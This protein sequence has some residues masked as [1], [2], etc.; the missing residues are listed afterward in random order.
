MSAKSIKGSR[1]I[2]FKIRDNFS[3]VKS[4]DTY[5][6]GQWVLS[7]FDAKRNL[8]YYELD[9]KHFKK[10]E[11]KFELIVTDYSNNIANFTRLIYW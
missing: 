8:L 2:N 4:Y 10:G 7:K 6:N 5:I 9:N 1:K 11:N 3:G